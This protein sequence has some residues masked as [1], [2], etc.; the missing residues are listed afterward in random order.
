M[1]L[2]GTEKLLPKSSGKF[3]VAKQ[4]QHEA[5][6]GGNPLESPN[7]LLGASPAKLTQGKQQDVTNGYSEKSGS[8]PKAQTLHVGQ[9]MKG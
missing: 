4:P 2:A 7:H 8:L 5:K 6:G 1:K 3:D 9:P